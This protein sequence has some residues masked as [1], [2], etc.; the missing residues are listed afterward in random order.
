MGLTASTDY[1]DKYS[2]RMPRDSEEIRDNILRLAKNMGNSR[3]Y[4][5]DIETLNWNES[6]GG[7]DTY[8]DPNNYSKKKPTRS[9]YNNHNPDIIIN[10][11]QQHENPVNIVNPNQFGGNTNNTNDTIYDILKSHVLPQQTGRGCGCTDRCSACG[12][13]KHTKN[14]SGGDC[15]CN[16]DKNFLNVGSETSPNITRYNNLNSITS[17]SA[18]PVDFSVMKGG[19]NDSRK[20]KANNDDDDDDDFEDD[21]ED[22]DDNDENEENEDDEEDEDNDDDNDDDDNENEEDDENGDD[23]EENDNKNNKKNKNKNK[24]V[25][26][27]QDKNKNQNRTTKIRDTKRTTRKENSEFDGFIKPF[28]S[29]DS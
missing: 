12:S 23:D 17:I 16:S 8:T 22:D 4:E 21:L 10:E 11:L 29:T 14:I 28:F 18:Q 13:L 6:L 5:T 7:G 27:N 3:E 25:T 19:G 20:N 24:K 26:S 15:G 1:D 2:T 9:R